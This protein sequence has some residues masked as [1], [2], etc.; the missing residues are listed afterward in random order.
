MRL[1]HEDE[2]SCIEFL[3]E[4]QGQEI[5]IKYSDIAYSSDYFG[6][7]MI[8][9]QRA[10]NFLLELYK[11]GL[12]IIKSSKIDWNG[13]FS[14]SLLKQYSGL[15]KSNNIKNAKNLAISFN[16]EILNETQNEQKSLEETYTIINKLLERKGLDISG[17]D[18]PRDLYEAI[19]IKIEVK[20]ELKE[21][22]VKYLIAFQNDELKKPESP[23]E[24][25]YR[26]RYFENEYYRYKKQREIFIDLLQKKLE[27]QNPK[28]IK[29]DLQ[30]E[31][32]FEH[33]NLGELLLCLENEEIIKDLNIETDF[34]DFNSIDNT[35]V[36]NLLLSVDEEK[37]LG[38]VQYKKIKLN[39]S[40]SQQIGIFFLTDQDGKEYKI[41]IQ[42]QV[43][44]EVLRIIF[45]NP[46]NTYSEWSLYDISDLLVGND[47]DETAVKNAIYQFNKKVKLSIPEVENIFELTKHSTKLNQKYIN[48]N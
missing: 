28:S 2:L 48:K 24:K 34:G 1:L 29:I 3:L 22:L 45:Q 20:K 25:W 10:L 26:V 31:L 40:F 5:M 14:D 41:K 46:K 8:G 37:T 39:L 21:Y 35:M 18:F 32:P 23:K 27:T 42:G 15:I 9:I 19:S 13:F 4:R 11:D 44:R 43:Q 36:K 6:D 12:I 7:E 16:L 30:K 33:L 38:Q 47:V 17:G